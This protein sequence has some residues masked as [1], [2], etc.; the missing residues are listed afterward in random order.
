MSDKTWIMFSVPGA[1]DFCAWVETAALESPMLA[2]A[3][4]LTRLMM[5]PATGQIG[6]AKAAEHVTLNFNALPY[7]TVIAGDLRGQLGKVWNTGEIITSEK[8][9][10]RHD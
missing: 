9:I 8:R 7:W 1:G 6:L 5:N 3:E 10:L 4:N 2:H